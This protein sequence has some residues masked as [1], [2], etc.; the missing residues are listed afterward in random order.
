MNLKRFLILIPTAAL[1]LGVASC[2]QPLPP[3]APTPRWNP[4]IYAHD[5]RTRIIFRGSHRVTVE[6]EE[7]DDYLSVR[8]SEIEKAQ[9]EFYRIINQCQ[10][11]K[12]SK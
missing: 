11:W 4:K 8:T 10:Q 3:G 1:S 6:S 5:S 7:F 9:A 12:A 2:P